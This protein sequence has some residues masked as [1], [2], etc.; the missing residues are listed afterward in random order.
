MIFSSILFLFYFLPV[1]LLLYYL[2]PE[3]FRNYIALLGS[4]LFYAWGAPRFVFL[5]VL[6]SCVDFHIGKYLSPC[7]GRRLSQTRRRNLLALGLILNVGTLLYF[8]YANF[9]V[10]ECLPALSLL[11]MDDF[12][13]THIALPIGISFFTFQKISYLI[14]A[15]RGT[16]RPCD[17]FSS[18]LLYVSLF[19]QLIAG[20]IIRYHDVARQLQSRKHTSAVFLSGVWRFSL[21]LS[22]KVII[23]N[24]LSEI[25]DNGFAIS[26]GVP[27]TS[28]AWL[29]LLCYTMQIYFD[30]SGYSDMAIGL[31]RM[32]GFEYLENFNFPYISRNFT[33]FWKRWHISLSNWMREYLYF[34]LGGNRG[35]RLRT[36]FNLWLVFLISGIWHGASWNFL[37]WGG[38]HGFFIS[39]DKVFGSI[40]SAKMP[41]YIGV[42]ATFILVM[43]GWVFFRA[44]D[45]HAALLYIAA[46]SGQV[47]V[48]QQI[49]TTLG[50]QS[51]HI[52]ILV[53]ALLF[54]FF[55]LL[56]PVSRIN[57][58]LHTEE[59]RWLFVGVR[60]CC[61]VVLLLL[62]ASFLVSANFNP[63]IYFRF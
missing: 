53:A 30:F 31:G 44:D 41:R 22:K 18:Y 14:D 45:L 62:S 49:I 34:P 26:Q 28:L 52:A 60:Y 21:G 39:I 19:P 16:S 63:F 3:R 57:P 43:I 50:I 5:L 2:T 4:L 35:G 42:P 59:K 48:S 23:A 17:K 20:P 8:K 27:E 37:I 13:W 32:L 11:G 12:H 7:E 58:I 55:P 40:T 54:S 47:P 36:S 33:E 25:A 61:S 51:H 46:L 15:Y 9:F 10:E 29:A 1:F 6:S 38:F 24:T 56:I